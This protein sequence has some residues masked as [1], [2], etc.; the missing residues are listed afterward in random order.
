MNCQGRRG[1]NRPA[2]CRRRGADC[3]DRQ[4]DCRQFLAYFVQPG[5]LCAGCRCAIA[6]GYTLQLVQTSCPISLVSPCGAG[7]AVHCAGSYNASA[8]N[9]QASVGTKNM[10]ELSGEGRR[11]GRQQFHHRCQCFNA[12]LLGMRKPP[13]LMRNPL[14]RPVILFSTRMS[15]S[16]FVAEITSNRLARRIGFFSQRLD[17][18]TL[19]FRCHRRLVPCAA[20]PVRAARIAYFLRSVACVPTVAPRLRAYVEGFH[21][22]DCPALGSVFLLMTD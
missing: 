7:S 18:F 3:R 4:S 6:A 11:T 15:C 22:R 21:H 14:W 20:R 10:R 9:A 17:V 19:P 5:H 16:F 12:A 1:R 13:S 8:D 2:T